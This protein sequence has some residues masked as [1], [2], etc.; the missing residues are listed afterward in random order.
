M[1]QS[2]G[3]RMFGSDTINLDR[4]DGMNFTCWKEKMKFMLTAFKVYYVLEGP[5]VGVMTE[6]E[7]RKRE[8]DETL[9]RGYILSTLTD[10]LYDLYTPMTS[11]REIWNSLE[12][13]YTAEK[14]GAD[15]FITF[16][17]FEFAMED[18]VSI[19]DQVHEF[20][21]LVSKFKNLNIEIPE[22]LLV[23]AIITKLPSSW[24]NYRKKLMHTS[25]D[26]TL[27]QIQKHLRI[28]EETR[29]R[30]KNLNGAS[31]SKVN[32]V[33]SGKNNKGN[34]KKRKGT[35]NSSKNN[36]TIRKT[37]NHCLRLCVTKQVDTTEFTATVS[38][39]NI[40]MIQELHMANVSTTNDWWYDSGATTHVCNNKDLF[41]TYKETEDGHEV[42]MG[43]NHTLK[44]IGSGNVEIQFTSGKKLTL[45]NVLHV[46]NIR[47]NL[48][49]GFKLCIEQGDIVQGQCICRKSIYFS[50]E[51]SSY[52]ESQGLIHQRTTPYTPQQ[53]GVTE[54]KNRVLQDMINAMLVS[55]NLPKNLW[56]EALLTD[57]IT[58]EIVTQILQDISG[59]DLNSNNKR[60]MAESSSAPR[61]SERAR[62]E[63]NLD[64]D[65]IDSQAIIFLVEGD[66]ENNVINKIPVLLNVED[67][68]KTYKEAITSRNSAFWKEAIDDE[69]DSLVSNNTWELSDLP[70]GSKAIGCRW[71]ESLG[72]LDEE[73]YMK[74][75]EGF[76]LPGHENKV[77]KLKKSLYGLKQAPKQ[78]HDKF[79]KSI[80]SNG[81][82]HNS[83]D[84]CIYS[85]FTKDY[86][87]IRCL[88]VDD[89]LIVRT[90][91]EG[92]N[93]T[94]KFLSSCFQMKDMNEVDTILGIKVKRHSGGYALNQCHY[95]DKIIDKFQH[96]NI[97]EANTPYEPDIAYAVCKL[98]RY[99][100]NPSHDHWK[101]IRRIF[102]YLKRTRQLALYYDRFPTV[103][104]G[105]SD[106]NWITGSSDNK[107][108]TGMSWYFQPR[109][110][111]L[112]QVEGVN[113]PDEKIEL[114]QKVDDHHQPPSPPPDIRR[115]P[116]TRQMSGG[117]W[118]YGVG[119]DGGV[120]VAPSKPLSIYTYRASAMAMKLEE[121]VRNRRKNRLAQTIS[122]EAGRNDEI[123]GAE[124]LK[125]FKDIFSNLNLA[126]SDDDD[127]AKSFQCI[128]HARNL[129]LELINRQLKSKMDAVGKVRPYL[130]TVPLVVQNHVHNSDRH[131]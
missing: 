94:K 35:W 121:A 25:E 124:A 3:L 6:E 20:L 76:V 113:P 79:D 4:M 58:N 60:N 42:M 67:A 97:E 74:Q 18:N 128:Q 72:D 66:N 12:E 32:Y 62:K 90:N 116:T 54:R 65:F 22:K 103:L 28:E 118:E 59:P 106:A 68:P 53:N 108:I 27:D 1:D 8:Q 40:G 115:P 23:G 127:P 117:G 105:Y 131:G 126:F 100:S 125:E 110:A 7:Q 77:C 55:A 107:S 5:H 17:F 46:P 92:I 64:P 104:E 119:G 49:S 83:S 13:K 75:P 69:M 2:A 95:I 85:K 96:L 57:V 39:I 91:M 14:E 15:K 19:L 120:G 112:V 78:W 44:V 24:H 10:R 34:D 47:K 109:N 56:G 16:K 51:F 11:A 29:I 82:T 130:L 89:I 114:E 101:E 26:F 86:G 129:A 93:E 98:S 71:Q 31:S 36:K 50:A 52:C 43:D 81:F 122:Q 84:R 38:E 41:K 123:G 99:S 48:V 87:V 9:C 88:Y 111:K 61:R 37:R 45:M 73:V 80:L 70:P 30:E 33:D 63:R 21:I 102:G